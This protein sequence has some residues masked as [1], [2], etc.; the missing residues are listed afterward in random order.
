MSKEVSNSNILFATRDISYVGGSER[1]MSEYIIHAAK[2][3]GGKSFLFETDG[4]GQ[5]SNVSVYDDLLNAG[6][7]TIESEN[8]ENSFWNPNNAIQLQKII[9]SLGVTTLHSFLI[10]ADFTVLSA[11]LGPTL[12][13]QLMESIPDYNRLSGIEER[14][15]YIPNVSTQ[16]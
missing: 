4:H 8:P 15:G 2:T 7:I 12:T 11:K 5:F 6:V 10:N 13:H 9:A 14:L 16:P 1:F 3:I